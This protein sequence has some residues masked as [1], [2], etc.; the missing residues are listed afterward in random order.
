MNE[1]EIIHNLRKIVKNPAAL[2]LND[3]VFFDRKNSLI[4]SIDTYNENI[5]YFNFNNPDLIIKKVIRSSISDIISK[6]VDP[7]FILISFSGSKNKF[8]KKNIKLLLNSIKQEQK[9][10]NFSLIG[11]DIT[12]S[13]KTSFTVCTFAY[14]KKIIKR[15]NCFPGDEIYVTGNIGDS[16]VGL[17][18]LNHKFN[19]S[20]KVKNYFIEKYF[21]PKLAYGF[22]RELFK[23][24]NSSMDISD[25]L[26]IDL[27]KML[28]NKKYGFSLDYDK[29]PKSIYF[30]NL[31]NKKKNLAINHLFKGDDYQILFTAKPSS[32]SII[33]KYSKMWNQKITRIGVITNSKGNYMK[34][35]N[36]N[37]KI[38]DYQGYIHNFK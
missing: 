9:K 35:N 38:K 17:S 10:Y 34:F 28:P 24:A 19:V 1:Y 11:G 15:I 23:F 13:A 4:A 32:R 30:K 20:N 21:K 22:H 33:L 8:T 6:G 18:I 29:L 3:D 2:K 36:K 37:I 27:K 31:L 12:S 14:S 7:K 25:G 5:H 16:S 26:L